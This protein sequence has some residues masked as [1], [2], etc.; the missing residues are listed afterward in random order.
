MATLGEFFNS[1]L[2]FILANVLI[3]ILGIANFKKGIVR[4][5]RV[6]F[7][8]LFVMV[9]FLDLFYGLYYKDFVYAT[10]PL[11]VVAYDLFATNNRKLIESRSK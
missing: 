2:L 11:F 3:V 1:E 7:L 10:L 5:N 6:R 8:V 4:E 9:L